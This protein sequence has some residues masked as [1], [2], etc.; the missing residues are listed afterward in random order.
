MPGSR[1]EEGEQNEAGITNSRS[2]RSARTRRA[3]NSFR[4]RAV[5]Q[6]RS[7]SRPRREQHDGDQDRHRQPGLN[8]SPNEPQAG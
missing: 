8:E 4:R 6:R 3:V 5:I 2:F 1:D 7:G